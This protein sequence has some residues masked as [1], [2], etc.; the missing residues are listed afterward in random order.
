MKRFDVT[1]LQGPCQDARGRDLLKWKFVSGAREVLKRSWAEDDSVQE[2][3]EA[4]KDAVCDV[5][6]S[7]LGQ[8]R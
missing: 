3:W 4:M 1:R 5:G 6:R 8:A 2:K 7:V